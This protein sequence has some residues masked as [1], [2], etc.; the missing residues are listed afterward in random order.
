MQHKSPLTPEAKLLLDQITVRAK[1]KSRGR[2]PK[3]LAKKRGDLKRMPLTGR[4][5][6]KAIAGATVR[7]SGLGTVDPA[8]RNASQISAVICG[9]CVFQPNFGQSRAH[10]HA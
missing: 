5:A 9:L 4:A 2:I 7:F 1:A 6:L 3:L 10:P 8:A